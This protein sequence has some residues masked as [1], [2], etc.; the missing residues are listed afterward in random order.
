MHWQSTP[1]ALPLL[2]TAIIAVVLAIYSWRKRPAPGATPFFIMMLAVAEWTFGYALELSSADLQSIVLWAKI[3]Y[4]GIV[5]GPVAALVLAL[6]YTGH[7]NWLTL[8]GR[9]LLT[10]VPITTVAL[11]W[12]NELHGL[13]WS[14]VRADTS[15]SVALLDVDYGV[16][17]IMHTAYSYLVMIFGILLVVLAFIRS[18]RPYRCSAASRP[19]PATLSTC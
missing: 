16:W 13:I 5:I 14:A 4:L 9:L 15:T 18:P 11:V 3:E 6:E 2:I 19:C 12:T 17:F 7:E 8:R 10:V 1:Y